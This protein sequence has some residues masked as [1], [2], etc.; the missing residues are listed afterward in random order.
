MSQCDRKKLTAIRWW[1]RRQWVQ[2]YL[3]NE[4]TM[5]TAL[6]RSNVYARRPKVVTSGLRGGRE[7]TSISRW[8]NLSGT[9]ISMAVRI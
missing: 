5:T 4:S 3:D 9:L 8:T 6:V 1:R 7:R 2:L